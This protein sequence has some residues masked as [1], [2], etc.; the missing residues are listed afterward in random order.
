MGRLEAGHQGDATA[1]GQGWQRLIGVHPHQGG[2]R[3]E[4]G[5]Q[6]LDPQQQAR[7]MIAIFV[8]GGL[9]TL[10]LCGYDVTRF[11]AKL[12]QPGQ[13]V[14]QISLHPENARQ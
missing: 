8:A 12:V 9:R 13:P 7:K 2:R 14:V 3:E 11:F 6:S 1:G 10:H 5:I 4:K